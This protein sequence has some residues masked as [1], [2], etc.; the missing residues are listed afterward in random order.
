MR[1][2]RS[3]RENLK[4]IRIA[5]TFLLSLAVI[6][7][8]VGILSNKLSKDLNSKGLNQIQS[9]LSL[10]A[11]S[12]D[13]WE[14]AEK[15]NESYMALAQFL[16]GVSGLPSQ[17]QIDGLAELSGRMES[18]EATKEEIKTFA[19][20]FSLLRSLNYKDSGEAEKITAATLYEI[21]VKIYPQLIKTDEKA[22][23]LVVP[24]MAEYSK[25]IA[26][27]TIDNI[28]GKGVTGLTVEREGES[29]VAETGNL[30]MSFSPADGSLEGFIYIR[31][32][33]Q[34]HSQQ[35]SEEERVEKALTF[36]SSVVR[37]R[38]DVNAA[39]KGEHCGFL[40]VDIESG[41]EKWRTAIDRDGEIWSFFKVEG[42]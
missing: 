5:Y 1:R 17:V 10:C 31:L 15:P 34:I 12:L 4:D 7:T 14:R 16:S 30:R 27:R 22:K 24:E 3:S 6:A 37:H 25:K 40:I 20:T 19:D 38:K 33:D 36:F 41:E 29:L 32:E 11:D 13:L 28:F 35:L 9:S 42:T 8:A 39:I 26:R 18:G 23:N 2:F 21:S